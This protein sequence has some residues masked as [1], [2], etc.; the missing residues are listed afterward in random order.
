V[1]GEPVKV[2]FPPKLGP[3][4]KRVRHAVVGY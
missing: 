3:L 1:D 2:A 4:R